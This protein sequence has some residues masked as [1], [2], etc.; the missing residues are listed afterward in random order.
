MRA[1]GAGAAP[2][3]RAKPG[4]NAAATAEERSGSA[5]GLWR[6]RCGALGARTLRIALL[7]QRGGETERLLV[8][9]KNARDSPAPRNEKPPAVRS[10]T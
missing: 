2:A 6:Y 3:G 9:M 5:P 8:F 4:L 1:R 7:P 10:S